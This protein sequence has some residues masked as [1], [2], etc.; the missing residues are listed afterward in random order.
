MV[1]QRK[2][3]FVER[4]GFA[5]WACSNCNWNFQVGDDLKIDS[6]GLDSLIRGI[7]SIRDKAFAEHV[8]SAPKKLLQR[9]GP[10]P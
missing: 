6:G 5:G 9:R 10:S 3:E 7:E 1:L 2:M 4:P 8:C